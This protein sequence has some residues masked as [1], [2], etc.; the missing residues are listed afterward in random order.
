MK[1]GQMFKAAVFLILCLV[2]VSAVSHVVV[3]PFIYRS[4]QVRADA[5]YADAADDT[6]SGA[7]MGT[8]SVYCGWVAPLAWK[9]YGLTIYPASFNGIPFFLYENLIKELRSRRAGVDFFVIDVRG[10]LKMSSPINEAFIRYV[11][12]VMPMSSNKLDALKRSFEVIETYNDKELTAAEKAAYYFPL[13]KYHLRWSMLTEEDYTDLPDEYKGAPPNQKNL[14]FRT[15]TIQLNPEAQTEECGSLDSLQEKYLYSLLDYAEQENLQ[16]LFVSY[17]AR[18]SRS[19]QLL[20]NETLRIAKSRGYDTLCFDTEEMCR[21]AELDFSADFRNNNHLNSKGALKM[22]RY[23]GSY[24][25]SNYDL[26]DHRG[27]E[28]YQSWDDSWTAYEKMYEEGWAK[29]EEAK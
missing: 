15:K 7:I 4:D 27:E 26:P 20:I 16:L 19:D 11:T 29:M 21:E 13:L 22:T 1:K 17:P 5:V 24:I 12:D 10:I 18:N 8:S 6:W 25:R 14:E 9:E 28:E 3:M 23:L 2:M